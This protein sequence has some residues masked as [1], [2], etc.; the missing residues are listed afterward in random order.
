VAFLQ[1]LLRECP[2]LFSPLT[3]PCFLPGQCVTSP[4][5]FR[6]AF[7][8]FFFLSLCSCLPPYRS[9]FP[10]PLCRILSARR[11]LHTAPQIRDT[12]PIFHYHT[13]TPFQSL[14]PNLSLSSPYVIIG[15]QVVL[16]SFNHFPLA[17][18]HQ[19]FHSF[20]L[21]VV[22]KTELFVIQEN[23]RLT[24]TILRLC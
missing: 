17:H 9:L 15:S 20:R 19:G 21:I 7:L 16:S 24:L 3:I 6:L 14:F 11:I 5:L 12:F 1:T 8:F 13:Q 18:F 2:L 10:L 22:R 4:G 23:Y